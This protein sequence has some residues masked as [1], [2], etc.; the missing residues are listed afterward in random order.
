[1]HK[2]LLVR[3][4]YRIAYQINDEEIIV[5]ILKIGSRENFYRELQFGC[6]FAVQAGRPRGDCP[7]N[8]GGRH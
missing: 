3:V 2:V 4:E 7:G 5:L 1:M 8:H 6:P